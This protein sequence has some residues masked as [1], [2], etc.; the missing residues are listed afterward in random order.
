MP[1]NEKERRKEIRH[2]VRTPATI[3]VV[4][5]GTALAGTTENVSSSGFLLVLDEHADLKLG[6]E[7]VCEVRIPNDAG[8]IDAAWGKGKLV[9]MD[10]SR[11]A[12]FRLGPGVLS[13]TLCQPC[14][15]CGGTG[16]VTSLETLCYDLLTKARKVAAEMDS[17]EVTVEVHPELAEWLKLH[18]AA[19]VAEFEQLTQK[20][21]IIQ[22]S[23]RVHWHQ[24]E[25]H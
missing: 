8:A 12:A 24:Y 16:V 7:V 11:V 4:R 25:I 5:D 13:R 20:R 19:L 18:H 23:S 1:H 6:E 2:S 10:D 21:L 14:P 22:A 9:R 15:C 17:A 3:Q